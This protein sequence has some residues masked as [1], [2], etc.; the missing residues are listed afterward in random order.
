[1]SG[2]RGLS[3]IGRNS[4]NENRR[5][6]MLLS[7]DDYA[8]ASYNDTFNGFHAKRKIGRYTLGKIVGQGSFGV[9][10]AAV[11]SDIVDKKMYAIKE[12]DLN[13]V[14]VSTIRDEIKILK[15]IGNK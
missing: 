12:V 2:K 14:N 1:M 9:V 11:D 8:S 4:I 10:R 6:N 5:N 7:N 3:V 13:L 15:I